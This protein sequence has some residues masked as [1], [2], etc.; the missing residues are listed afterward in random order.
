MQQINSNIIAKGIVKAIFSLLAVL[1]LLWFLYKIKIVIIYILIALV[2][3][4]IGRPVKKF[5]SSKFKLNDTPASA[6]TLLLILSIFGILFAVLV[7]M[8]VQQ[9][10]NLSALDI[11][12]FQQKMNLL[13]ENIKTY[14]HQKNIGILDD[15]TFHNVLAQINL[16]I[17]PGLFNSIF[18]IFG[19]IIVGIFAVSFISFFMLKDNQ[20]TANFLFRLIPD[21]DQERFKAVFSK[22]KDLL[23]RYFI[24]ISIQ[25]TI[26]FVLY[27]ILLTFLDVENAI[28]IALISALMNLVPYIGPVVGWIIII[29]LSMTSQLNVL[30]NSALIH[31]ARNITI[32]YIIVQIWDAFVD[33]PLIYSKSVKAHP[34]EIFLVIMIAGALSGVLGMIIAVPTYTMLRLFFKEFYEEY[35]SQFTIW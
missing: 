22:I 9:A 6:L 16:K 17:L 1:L 29:S 20:L 32:G 30:D 28:F 24:G 21:D 4:L 2:V 27:T 14:L 15:F 35:K 31:L 5:F 12:N 11:D 23:S 34:L 18:E 33:V 13:L 10:Q 19:N 7:P 25:I 3:S 26:I 8:I